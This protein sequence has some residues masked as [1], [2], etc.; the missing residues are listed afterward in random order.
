MARRIAE[1]HE[2]I[3][4]LE[5]AFDGVLIGG[6]HL[7]LLIGAGHPPYTATPGYALEHYGSGDTYE[8]WCCWRSIMQARQA[9]QETDND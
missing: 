9:L 1:L 4:Q 6:N 5:A 2:R 7:A 8:I 3:E